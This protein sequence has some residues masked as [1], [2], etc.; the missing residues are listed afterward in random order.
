M[1]LDDTMAPKIL[2]ALG[3]GNDDVVGIADAL[4]QKPNRI[5][6]VFKYVMQNIGIAPWQLD[7]KCIAENDLDPLR[8]GI[9]LVGDF[10]HANILALPTVLEQVVVDLASSTTHVHDV[11]TVVLDDESAQIGMDLALPGE[12]DMGL[13]N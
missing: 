11:S 5:F 9:A 6:Y 2:V 4:T 7:T 13:C 12:G 8:V 1:I 10:I 3:N